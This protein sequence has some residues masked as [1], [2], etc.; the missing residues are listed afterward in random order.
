[1]GV[2]RKELFIVNRLAIRW[3]FVELGVSLSRLGTRREL[4]LGRISCLTDIWVPHIS[5]VS[6]DVNGVKPLAM[7]IPRVSGSPHHEICEHNQPSIPL[8]SRSD[9]SEYP[10]FMV[11]IATFTLMK[12]VWHLTVSP[13]C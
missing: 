7:P 8:P 9:I 11:K 5:Q 10:Q 3:D 2:W 4:V 1:M 13:T 6:I 12:C